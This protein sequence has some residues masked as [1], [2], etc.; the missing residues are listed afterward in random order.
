MKVIKFRAWDTVN[1]NME[2]DVHYLDSLNEIIGRDKYHVMQ[3]T[4]LLDEN[5]K[6][7]YDGD[8]LHYEYE[9][10]PFE[11]IKWDIDGACWIT[12]EN[13]LSGVDLNDGAVIVGNI[14]ENPE[15]L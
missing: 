12:S 9:G 1:N 3:F 4:G 10:V 14:Y 5:G 13:G 6:E 8:I 2:L 11:Y 15:L 7:I